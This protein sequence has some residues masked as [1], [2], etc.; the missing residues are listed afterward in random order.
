MPKLY[1]IL[2]LCFGSVGLW[3]QGRLLPYPDGYPADS[4]LVML[5][6]DSTT[7]RLKSW[8]VNRTQDTLRVST[9]NGSI[10]EWLEVKDENGK[11]QCYDGNFMMGCGMGMDRVGLLAPNEFAM[12]SKSIYGYGNFA[13]EVRAF[14][15]VN[16]SIR[17]SAPISIVIDAAD[18]DSPERI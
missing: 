3:A 14:F 7:N 1:L 4:L 12:K 16:D 17:Y 13:T 18:I 2:W 15:T 11:W 9:P 5:L 8:L 6:V 10:S